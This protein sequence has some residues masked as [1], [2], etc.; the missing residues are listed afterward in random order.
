MQTSNKLHICEMEYYPVCNKHG[1]R[2]A[3]SRVEPGLHMD[4]RLAAGHLPLPPQQHGDTVGVREDLSHARDPDILGHTSGKVGLQRAKVS[5][6]RR[7]TLTLAWSGLQ[8]TNATLGKRSLQESPRSIQPGRGRL[9]PGQRLF[10]TRRRDI[11]TCVIH[12][13]PHKTNQDP[14]RTSF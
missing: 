12:S 13:I 2:I 3:T 5:V 4:F 1:S 14:P 11:A 8:S 9:A 10:F 6:E 7:V